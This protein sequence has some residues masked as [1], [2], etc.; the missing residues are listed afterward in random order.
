MA[1]LKPFRPVAVTANDL[2]S[3]AVVY[4]EPD[5]GWG[6]D[7][8]RAQVAENQEA[9]DRLLQLATADHHACLVVEPVLIEM[10]SGETRRPVTLRERIRDAGPTVGPAR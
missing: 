8:S 10:S 1:K 2:R 7:A 4:R 6:K 3:G 5:G 9:A